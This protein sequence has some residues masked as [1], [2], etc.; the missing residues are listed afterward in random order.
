[1]QGLPDRVREQFL[2][3]GGEIASEHTVER[4][5]RLDGGRL[6]LELERKASSDPPRPI[7]TTC[8]RR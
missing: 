1:M 2:K 7:A 4:V 6:R 8:D 3:L 5:A